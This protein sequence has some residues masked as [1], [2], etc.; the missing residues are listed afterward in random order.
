MPLG[1]QKN[2][3]VLD[4]EI[5]KFERRRRKKER[6]KKKKGYINVQ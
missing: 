4:K 6:G 1:I 2:Q 5:S 3:F